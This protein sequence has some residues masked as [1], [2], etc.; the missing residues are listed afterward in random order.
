MARKCTAARALHPACYDSCGSHLAGKWVQDWIRENNARGT[1]LV[2]ANPSR[3]VTRMLE[4]AGIPDKLGR[5]FISVRM[6]DAVAM[7]QVSA[8]LL[9]P[10]LCSCI[11]IVACRS[12]SC[13]TVTCLFEQYLVL[14]TQDPHII[15]HMWTYSCWSCSLAGHCSMC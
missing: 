7:C 5:R 2:F 9:V 1:Q 4:N 3:Q 6:D 15:A 11:H 12:C 14:T 13:V 10:T 8:S